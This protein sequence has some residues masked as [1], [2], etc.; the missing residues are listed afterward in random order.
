MKKLL[1]PTVLLTFLI[2]TQSV[3][4][5]STVE[6]DPEIA[7]DNAQPVITEDTTNNSVKSSNKYFDLE[8]KRG[9]QNPLNNNITYTLTVIPRIDSNETQ[10]TWDLP[11]TLIAKPRHKE[12]VNLEKDNTYTFTASI[13]PQ[14]GGTYD[15]TVNVNSW[16]PGTNYTNSVSTT[17][18]LSQNKVV[19]PVDSTYIVFL[20]LFIVAILAIGG[21]TIYFAYKYSKVGIAILKKWLTPPV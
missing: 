2:L 8:L 5:D 7:T 15:V 17:V 19:Q 21:V 16:Q 14:R 6:I 13:S 4:A 18:T 20:V 3:F 9:F 12:F 10:I 11:T 1:L